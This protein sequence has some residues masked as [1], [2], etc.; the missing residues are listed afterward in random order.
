MKA[1]IDP[2]FDRVCD[3]HPTGFPVAYPLF[4]VACDADTKP[5]ADTWD[6]ST[7]AIRKVMPTVS[8][9]ADLVI[10]DLGTTTLEEF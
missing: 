9:Q 4:W 10:S 6:G 3:I 2:R 1:L 5:H 8:E 7:A